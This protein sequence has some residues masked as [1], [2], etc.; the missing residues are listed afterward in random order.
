MKPKLLLK[1]LALTAIASSASAEEQL[2]SPI[3]TLPNTISPTYKPARCLSLYTAIAEWRDGAEANM[4]DLEAN[5]LYLK[6]HLEMLIVI[7]NTE[8][9]KR[10]VTRDIDDF[11][12]AYE[13]MLNAAYFQTGDI[14]SN[15]VVAADKQFCDSLATLN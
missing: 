2:F 4:P 1:S 13:N 11:S 12:S 15:A 6:G 9:A 5:G 3:D 14:Y 7:A 8:N 10:Y